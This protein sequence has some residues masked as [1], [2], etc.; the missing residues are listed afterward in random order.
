MRLGGPHEIGCCRDLITARSKEAR[1]AAVM[2]VRE[3]E[4]ME[5]VDRELRG[6]CQCDGRAGVGVKIKEGYKGDDDDDDN[7]DDAAAAGGGGEI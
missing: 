5:V 6:G 7:D 4:R 3:I 2:A 1:W